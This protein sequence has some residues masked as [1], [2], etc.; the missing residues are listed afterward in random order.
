MPGVSNQ[1]SNESW[2]HIS[3]D[4]LINMTYKI[5]A[6]QVFILIVGRS[7]CQ[8]VSSSGPNVSLDTATAPPLSELSSS[9]P[10]FSLTSLIPS[11]S[12]DRSS[13][14]SSTSTA[15]EEVLA[16]DRVMAN[17]EEDPNMNIE[18][19]ISK[20]LSTEAVIENKK[21]E[22]P[23]ID[24][25]DEG[26]IDLDPSSVQDDTG[27][28]GEEDLSQGG[29]ETLESAK[30]KEAA[31]D[32]KLSIELRGIVKQIQVRFFGG[33]LKKVCIFFYFKDMQK[34]VAAVLQEGEM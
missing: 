13:V 4:K 11:T 5:I 21:R 32:D 25:Q 14:D 10:T 27:N 8:D 7:K 17:E 19:E 33:Y 9:D 23:S 28:T 22:L 20:L 34:E 31:L 12:S 26:K 29:L 1:A 18:E 2:S 16:G 24:F 30:V 6:L 3:C 15:T